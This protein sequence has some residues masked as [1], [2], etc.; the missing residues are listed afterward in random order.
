MEPTKNYSLPPLWLALLPV[1]VLTGSLYYVIFISRG[2]PHGP[3]FLGTIS[4][5][6]SAY[7][8]GYTWPE[9]ER[10]MVNNI[11]KA[12][13]SLLILLI[14]GMVISLWIASGI[15]PA[16]IYYGFYILQPTWFL[17]AVM[18]LCSLMSLV[19]GSSWTTIGTI[20]VA[21]LGLGQ[22]MGVPG[23]ITAGAI[24]S[25]AFFGDKVSPMSDSTNLT[26]SI[27]GVDLFEHIGHMIYTTAPAFILSL[28]LYAWLGFSYVDGTADLMYVQ[29]YQHILM[30]HF[31]F[32]F[33]LLIPPLVVISLVLF[34]VPA[35]PSLTA[36]VLLGGL[37]Q[38][39]VQGYTAGQVFHTAYA[40]FQIMTGN[41]AFD[42]LLS[43]GGMT[44]MYSVVAL[45]LLALAFGAS[46][47]Q[48]IC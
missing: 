40:G 17:P 3:L 31:T 23:A 36:G 48:P 22:G 38:V 6:L 42:Q 41:E 7:F 33:W 39:L 20:G 12:L 25:G 19:T 24:V 14:I 8:Y 5:G 34:K 9:I 30:E 15:V 4:A 44:S 32:S 11:K 47:R 28:A 10:G 27:L 29:Q 16:M 46:W 45:G 13:P 1:L 21:A 37:I 18:L 2:E 26:P 43:R 35:L